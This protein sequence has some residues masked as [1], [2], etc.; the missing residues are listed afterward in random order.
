[1]TRAPVALVVAAA[2]LAQPA[3]INRDKLVYAT[4]V[5][6][7]LHELRE[8]GQAQVST[9]KKVEDKMFGPELGTIHLTQMVGFAGEEVSIAELAENCPDEPVPDPAL[10]T[11]GCRLA[12]TG[13]APLTLASERHH[14]VD[15]IGHA[16]WITTLVGLTV[17]GGV[18]TF[19][20]DNT[21]LQVTAGVTAGVIL[22]Y[23]LLASCAHSS[24]CHD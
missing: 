14:A 17:G 3:C 13:N 9:Y 1:M 6:L 16:L 8:R 10:P 2:A 24:T 21:P 11:N 12:E 20:C 19:A 7:H 4:E 23:A 18:C 22:I 15:Q 5:Q